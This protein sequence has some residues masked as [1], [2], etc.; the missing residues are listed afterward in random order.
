MTKSLQYLN[1]AIQYHK[2]ITEEML[3]EFC[4][5]KRY[6]CSILWLE[7]QRKRKIVNLLKFY[8]LEKAKGK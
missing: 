3:D 5:Q 6:T 8:Q 4:K 2:Q 1:L 7:Q